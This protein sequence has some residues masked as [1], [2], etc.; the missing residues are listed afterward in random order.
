MF[1]DNEIEKTFPLG[2]EPCVHGKFWYCPIF[3]D[4]CGGK[5]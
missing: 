1:P 2:K 4:S 5:C 3:Q